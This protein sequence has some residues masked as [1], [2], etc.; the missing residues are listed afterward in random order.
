LFHCYGA[1][2]WAWVSPKIE[3]ME[4]KKLPE[5][6]STVKRYISYPDGDLMKSVGNRLGL[7]ERKGA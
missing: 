5:I 7:R 4:D 6:A 3:G 1:G 2:G